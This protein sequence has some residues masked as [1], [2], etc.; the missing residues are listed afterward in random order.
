MAR[1]LAEALAEG[2]PA[3]AVVGTD[4][5]ELTPDVLAQGGQALARGDLALGPA[6]D[7]GYY[8][9]GLTRSAPELFQ[10]LAWG[11]DQVAAR[12]LELARAHGFTPALLPRLADLDRPADLPRWAA[13]RAREQGR[14]AVLIP[15]LNEEAALP[16]CLARV[17]AGGADLVVVADGGSADA[18]RAVAARAG[19]LVLSC[20][21]GRARQM[22][23]AARLATAEY[24][25]F[26][27]ADTLLPPGW[28]AEVRRVLADPGVAAG[29][30]TFRLDQ[31]PA[32]LRFIELAVALRCRLAGLPYGDQGLFLR[33]EDFQQLGG[34]PDQ[35]IMEDWELVRRL[36]RQGRVVI[37][38]LPAV[39][40]ARRWQELGLARTT[41]LNYL[42]PMLYHLGLEPARLRRLYDR[43]PSQRLPAK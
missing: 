21:R 7:G 15:A 4:L 18:T 36:G 20:P 43:R 19:A 34:F 9:I 6:A 1:C 22:N 33:R 3:A 30:F 40:S 38:P 27:H 24:L 25:L 12:T 29:A 8:F 10:G 17:A 2:A 13:A 26:L 41:F 35:P 28:A 5:P 37:S 11:G 39:T 32:S 16:S 31:R 23:A 42:V 14:L